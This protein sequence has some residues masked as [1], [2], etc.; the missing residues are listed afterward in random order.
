[1][2]S[3]K[4]RVFWTWTHESNAIPYSTKRHGTSGARYL[5]DYATNVTLE[6][7]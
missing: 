6:K 5:N 7:R 2:T 1:M 4:P 3:T